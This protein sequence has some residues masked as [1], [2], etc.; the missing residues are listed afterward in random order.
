MPLS[1]G[2]VILINRSTTNQLR[3]SIWN[4]ATWSSF[5]TIDAAAVR[6]TTYDVGMSATVD[7]TSGDIYLAYT[8]DNDNYTVAD[9]DLRT[10]I[11]NGSTW[12]AATD[13]IT[14][15]PSRALLQVAIGRDLNNGDIYVGYTARSAIADRNSVNV[16][17]VRSSDN[18]TTWGS[19]QGPLNLNSGNFTASV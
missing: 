11:F 3:S 5:S 7:L 12:S 10:Q 16:Y 18:M 2:N 13:I 6:N 9:H 17:Y 8:T 14:N 1:S 4:G 19:E 15:D